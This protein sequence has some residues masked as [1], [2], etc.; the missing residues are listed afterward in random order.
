MIE[1]STVLSVMILVGYAFVVGLI[2]ASSV[3]ACLA[4]IEKRRN[5]RA[6]YT[7]RV[8]SSA[9]ASSMMDNAR[10]FSQG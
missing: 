6:L 3:Y 4:I 7:G 2:L 1:V 5:G 9:M 8:P 10:E